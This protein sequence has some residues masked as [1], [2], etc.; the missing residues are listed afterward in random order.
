MGFIGLSAAPAHLDVVD[1]SEAHPKSDK[2]RRRIPGI[3]LQDAKELCRSTGYEEIDKSLWKQLK[4]DDSFLAHT[5]ESEDF[6][7]LIG[8][9]E[10]GIELQGRSITTGNNVSICGDTNGHA[11][12]IIPFDFDQV[13][14]AQGRGLSELPPP[15]IA[16]P[17]R[18]RF[19]ERIKCLSASIDSLKIPPE[20][21][22]IWKSELKTVVNKK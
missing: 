3:L 11:R 21:K 18:K 6:F 2:D 9:F 15:A 7:A 17:A 19:L 8:S 1:P 16:P 20:Q 10:H 5:Q 22:A 14:L 13:E 4:V 12:A